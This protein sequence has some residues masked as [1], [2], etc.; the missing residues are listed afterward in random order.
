M[1]EQLK[2]LAGL[3]TEAKVWQTT[4]CDDVTQE[5]RL[6]SARSLVSEL[7]ASLP[8]EP[9]PDD[10]PSDVATMRAETR[11]REDVTVAPNDGGVSE[12]W[13]R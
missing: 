10:R 5:Q 9:D 8:R 7:R 12:K 11:R 6:E 4:H 1:R 3:L 2:K 13:K